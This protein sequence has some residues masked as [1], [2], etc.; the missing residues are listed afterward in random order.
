MALRGTEGRAGQDKLQQCWPGDLH[1]HPLQ[2]LFP[3]AAAG[4]SG[5]TKRW[6]PWP[7]ALRWGPA[8]AVWAPE[9]EG[10]GCSRVLF[11]QLSRRAALLGRKET[12]GEALKMG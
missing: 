12:E 7:F 8:G 1:Q 4:S 3:S 6:L 5:S 2:P 11:G 10:S 9:Q